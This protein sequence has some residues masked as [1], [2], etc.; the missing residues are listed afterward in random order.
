VGAE[1]EEPT[2]DFE[3][4][5]LTAP[6][7]RFVGL[8]E[9]H[10]T[11]FAARADQHDREGSFPFE[12]MEAL[13]RSCSLAAFVP[14]EFGGLG[15][16]SVHDYVV[17]MSRLGRG[18]GSTAIA[19]NMHIF[20]AWL[21]AR[22]RK[23]AHAAGHPAR[24]ERWERLLRGIGA[25]EIV[26][27][28]VISEP[29]T[30]MLHPLVEAS[31]TDGGWLL[32]GTKIFGTGS[33]AADL[34]H[35][36]YRVKDAAGEYRRA[37]VLV[38]RGAPG[39]EV[40][41]N[42]DALGMRGSGSHDVVF[43]DCFVPDGEP[44]DTGP[45]G[46]WSE[47]FLGS[48]TVITMGLVGVF[49]GIAERARELI[50]DMVKG[51]RKGAAGRPQAQRHAIQHTIAEIEIDLAA[52][53]AMLART[54]AAADGFFARHPAG[55]VPIDDLHQLAKDFQCTKWF[56]TRKAIDIVDRAL[57]ASGG[58]GYLTKSPLSRLYRDV[59][60]GP[61]MQPFSPNEAF[62]YIGKVALGLELVLES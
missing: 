44:V 47:G 6:G 46:E 62:E 59:R 11:D 42:W 31:R 28:A 3:L 41:G 13:K 52:S 53:R 36:A 49:L 12:N 17:G 15:L 32:N 51:R 58:G 38:P 39:L 43:T 7:A 27:C 9:E 14:E 22:L 35:V 50:V 37:L 26:I 4:T 23:A 25:G 48:N 33:P 20:R 18:D 2:M 61:F 30:D 54:G 34:F 5:A 1:K 16:E 60:A 21:F 8:A 40:K 55:R 56:V 45:W 57:T 29:G 24:A 19:A 10:A